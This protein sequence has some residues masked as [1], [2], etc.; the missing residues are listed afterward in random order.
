MD[1]PISS[2]LNND[3]GGN[4]SLS[5]ENKREIQVINTNSNVCGCATVYSVTRIIRS[6]RAAVKAKGTLKEP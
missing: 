6:G 2:I 4:D 3:E 5:H 1:L